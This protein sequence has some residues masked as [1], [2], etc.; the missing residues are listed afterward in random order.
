MGIVA[1]ALA[2]AGFGVGQPGGAGL[3]A[4]AMLAAITAWG[5]SAGARWGRYLSVLAAIACAGAGLFGMYAFVAIF[6]LL[7]YS[8]GRISRSDLTVLALLLLMG[9]TFVVLLVSLVGKHRSDDV[10]RPQS[11]GRVI[12][13]ALGFAVGIAVSAAFSLALSTLAESPCCSA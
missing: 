5:I 1:A 13:V 8:G 11:R 7:G 9:A 10:L 2:Y 3:L 4:L 12:P 6:G